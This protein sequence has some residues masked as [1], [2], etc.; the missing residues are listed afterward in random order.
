MRLYNAGLLDNLDPLV[1]LGPPIQA[2]PKETP[3]VVEKPKHNTSCMMQSDYAHPELA[4]LNPLKAYKKICKD[5]FMQYHG[6]SLFSKEYEKELGRGDGI[7]YIF[8]EL[9]TVI[10]AKP[11][12]PSKI[13]L[14]GGHVDTSLDTSGSMGMEEFYERERDR[15]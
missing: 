12:Y 14:P 10:P 3:P 4:H 6:D 8:R 1:R 15:L 5:D 7:G 9:F 11:R 2:T 13:A